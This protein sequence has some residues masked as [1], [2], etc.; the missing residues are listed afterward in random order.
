MDAHV[1]ERARVGGMRR[2][3]AAALP[4]IALAAL[5]TL[6]VLDAPRALAAPH[7]AG[8]RPRTPIR[9]LI[10][11]VGENRTFDSVFGVYEPRGGATVDNLLARGIVTREGLP[12]PNYALAVQRRAAATDHYSIDPPR[13]EAYAVLPRPRLIGVRNFSDGLVG[14]SPDIRFPADLPP[15]PFQISRYAPYRAAPPAFTP[16]EARTAAVLATGDPPHRFFQMWQQ[17]GGDNA[18]GDLYMWV[19]ETAGMGGDTDDVRQGDTGQ[20]GE[21]MGFYNMA[22]GDAPYLRELADRYAISDNYHQSVM[23]GTGMNFY[24][25]VTGDLPV[26]RSNGQLGP[27]PENQRED[28]DPV[29]G[30]VNYYR[31][32]GYS[33]GSWVECANAS[34]PGVAPIRARLEQLHVPHR[35]EPGAWYLV[36]NLGLPYDID[37]REQPLGA[38]NFN[39]PPQ[40]TP[41]IAEALSGKGVAWKW[42]I[43]GRDEGD[44]A[45]DMRAR[46][47]NATEARRLQYDDVADPLVAFARINR[48]PALRAR[49][50][51]LASLDR[52]IDS[53]HLPAVS[54]VVPGNIDN[55]H[56]GNSVLA[57]YEALLHRIVDAVRA[58][59][60]LWAGTAIVATTDEGGGLYDSGYIQ[61]VDFFGDGPRIP[62]L[63]VSPHARRGHVDHVYN[64]HTSVLKFIEYNWRLPPLSARSRDNL[65]APQMDPAHP[66][67]PLNQ[68]AV[69]DLTTLFDFGRR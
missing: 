2:L 11:F 57:S 15:G 16:G 7:A 60:A 31:R 10:V 20:G 28:P 46:G 23:G 59:P 66:Y 68:P 33:G 29:A 41:N 22:A 36:N 39:M 19:G 1:Q 42:Y 26:Y 40:E 21:V 49:L 25:L 53:G 34:A 55:G 4:G 14:S 62:L 51:G 32:D 8:A 56:P 30:S 48:E 17:T 52:D 3:A 54:F 43:G 58:H 27:P 5:A 6:A 65:P 18:R 37:G 45:Y 63:V 38:L 47:M 61:S 12:G 69:G 13:L 44:L 67:R 64:D 35:C 24:A 9:H 50:A